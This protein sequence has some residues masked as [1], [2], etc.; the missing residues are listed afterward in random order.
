VS[1]NAESA[2]ETP[3]RAEK[4]LFE[5]AKGAGPP[6]FGKSPRVEPYQ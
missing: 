3:H 4:K 2:S 1:R 6:G 5:L